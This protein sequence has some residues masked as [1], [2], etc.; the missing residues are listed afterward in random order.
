MRPR[1]VLALLALAALATLTPSAAARLVG[2]QAPSEKV[3]CYMS[4]QGARCDV[5]R[6]RWQAPPKPDDCELDYGQGV[7]VGRHGEGHFV[8]AGDTT[9][10]PGHE[11]LDDGE[12]IK[13]GRFRCKNRG[14]STIRC[15]NTRT[16][17]GFK[18][19]KRRVRLF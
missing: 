1:V 17:S 18:V 19:S 5:A 12:S 15:V 7:S 3:G 10:D 4:G 14:E 9:L 16:G 13:T 6:P 8:C 11:V 2:F